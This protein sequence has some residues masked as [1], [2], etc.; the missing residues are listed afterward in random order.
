MFR[1]SSCTSG[2]ISRIIVILKHDGKQLYN[3]IFHSPQ[4]VFHEVCGIHVS[5]LQ[6][7]HPVVQLITNIGLLKEQQGSVSCIAHFEK[8]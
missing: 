6:S 5:C 8:E 1:P 2:N 7:A 3:L 4:N